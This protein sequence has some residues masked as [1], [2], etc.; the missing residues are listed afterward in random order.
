[1]LISD[2]NPTTGDLDTALS[3]ASAQGVPIDVMPLE[4][5]VKSEVLVDRFTAPT[6]KRE[7]EPFSIEVILRSTNAL[8]INGKLTVTHNGKAMDL[9]AN[10]AGVQPTRIVTLQPG[11]NVERVLV[12]PLAG[13]EDAGVIHQFRAIFEGENVSAQVK[14]TGAKAH[15]SAVGLAAGDTL[16][17]NNVAEAFTFVRG[18]GK[19]LYIDNV[20][21]GNGQFLRKALAEEG[22]NLE[23]RIVGADSFPKSLLELQNYDAVVLANVPRGAGGLDDDQQKMLAAYVHDMGGGLVM[24]GGDSGFGAGGWGGSKLEEVLPVNMDIPSQ[25]QMPKGALVLIMHSCEMPNGNYW[26]EQCALKAIETLSFRDEIGVISYSWG[27]GGA[28]WDFKLAGKGDGSK[29]NAAVK[30]MQLG[31]MPSFDDTLDLALHGSTGHDG[32]LDSDARQRHIIAI[33]DGDPAPPK[34]SLINE[35]NAA[36]ISISTVS[37]YPH[38]M[39][40]RGLPPNMQRMAEATKGRAYGPINNN[41]NQLPQIFQT[42]LV[43]GVQRRLP[44][45]W[46]QLRKDRL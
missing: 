8:P 23:D 24:I 26:G 13:T 40:D 41:P 14:S 1:V 25:R 22:I 16:T 27:A 18:K 17:D 3:A 33:S 44:R 36:S 31:D 34:Q 9:D 11:R 39:S 6:W 42:L 37:V 20:A 32:L 19:V 2:G 38:D 15:G 12:P 7:N 30:N 21:N 5:D 28:Q 29:V 4:Y 43:A 10:T 45:K 35:C 46:R